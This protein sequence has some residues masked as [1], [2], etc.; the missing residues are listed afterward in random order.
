ML[1]TYILILAGGLYS[2]LYLNDKNIFLAC[3]FLP[4]IYHFVF[5]IGMAWIKNDYCILAD[6]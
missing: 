5:E 3:I 2:L 1:L 4:I 6:F